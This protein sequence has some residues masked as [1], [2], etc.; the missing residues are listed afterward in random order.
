MENK[1][2]GCINR[3][4]NAVCNMV[5]IVN[6]YLLYKKRLENYCRT[7][8]DKN[9]SEQDTIKVQGQVLSYLP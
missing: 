7:T 9:L 5:K 3:D 2:S 1:Q 8:K 4:K 6:Y